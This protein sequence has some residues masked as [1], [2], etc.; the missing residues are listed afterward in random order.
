MEEHLSA[1]AVRIL[2]SVRPAKRPER[3]TAMRSKHRDDTPVWQ[4]GRKKR[5]G[6]AVTCRG[7]EEG[8]A[9]YKLKRLHDGPHEISLPTG[10]ASKKENNPNSRDTDRYISISCFGLSVSSYENHE[11]NRRCG[12]NISGCSGR[13]TKLGGLSA[14]RQHLL[15]AEELVP[16]GEGVLRQ[17]QLRTIQW[18]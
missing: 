17:G 7:A 13:R 8:P 15:R 12:S 16:E 14:E 2:S 18:C 3:N 4:I 11:D 1:F 6:G 5:Q 9:K 10:R